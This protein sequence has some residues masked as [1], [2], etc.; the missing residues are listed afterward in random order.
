[1]L[2]SNFTQLFKFYIVLKLSE[3]FH[4]HPVFLN[5]GW[6]YKGV[7]Y[8]WISRGFELLEIIRKT[9]CMLLQGGM[10]SSHKDKQGVFNLSK[11]WLQSMNPL[12]FTCT[13]V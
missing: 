4:V 2:I 3:C 1:M 10:Q 11:D 7:V 8:E 5:L 13:M 12:S 6:G 9:V